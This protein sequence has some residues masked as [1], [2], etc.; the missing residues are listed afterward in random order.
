MPLGWNGTKETEEGRTPTNPPRWRAI[1]PGLR[2]SDA[3]RSGKDR[4]TLDAQ[5]R[6]AAG[7]GLNPSSAGTSSHTR[8]RSPRGTSSPGP[9][10]LTTASGTAYVIGQVGV[11]HHWR[12]PS[13]RSRFVINRDSVVLDP[14][15]GI[16][17]LTVAWIQRAT[18]PRTP[19]PGLLHPSWGWV[20]W[21]VGSRTRH[22]GRLATGRPGHH[23]GAGALDGR[24][25]AATQ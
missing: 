1:L 21:R 3:G 16:I 14:D 5:N 15:E 18:P 13:R 6:P 23:A 11:A 7:L 22:V 4:T 12:R 2:P 8:G 20:G 24:G 17:L 10:G 25:G 19:G 9:R